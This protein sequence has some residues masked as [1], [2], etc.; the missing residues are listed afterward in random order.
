[1]TRRQAISPIVSIFGYPG[2][3]IAASAAEHRKN[4]ND[5]S[6]EE[7]GKN[8]SVRPWRLETCGPY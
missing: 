7:F 8:V 4:E 1:V 5:I 3:Q 6:L 2:E